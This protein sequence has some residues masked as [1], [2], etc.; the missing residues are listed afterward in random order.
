MYL[1][2]PLESAREIQKLS[3]E[4]R[5]HLRALENRLDTEATEEL[6]KIYQDLEKELSQALE[7]KKNALLK[8]KS[9]WIP[10]NGFS[11]ITESE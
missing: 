7:E 4:H 10:V 3:S 1:I 5:E 8:S 11:N 2:D 6:Y 9:K